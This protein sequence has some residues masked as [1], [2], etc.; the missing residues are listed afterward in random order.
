MRRVGRMGRLMTRRLRVGRMASWQPGLADSGMVEMGRSPDAWDAAVVERSNLAAA[1]AAA[2]DKRLL[3]STARLEVRIHT[4]VAMAALRTRLLAAS[5]ADIPKTAAAVV[6]ADAAYSAPRAA[7]THLAPPTRCYTSARSASAD[8]ASLPTSDVS[9]LFHRRFAVVYP[10]TSV[11]GRIAR[12]REGNDGN[13]DPQT[14]RHDRPF[15][16]KPTWSP[17]REVSGQTSVVVSVRV[18]RRVPPVPSALHSTFPVNS[19]RS[20]DAF[21]RL[22]LRRYPLAC[23]R[24][25]MAHGG[26]RRVEIQQA[27]TR[28]HA[29]GRHPYPARIVVSVYSALVEPALALVSQNTPHTRGRGP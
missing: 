22:R 25:V 2:C 27:T 17:S 13:P 7:D 9:S 3:D 26:Y 5:L 18:R 11:L 12:V 8:R 14:R 28:S 6:V 21:A 24:V 4:D 1:V 19:P 15:A 20:R 29:V 16:G 23:D 10:S